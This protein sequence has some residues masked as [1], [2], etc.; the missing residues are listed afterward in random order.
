M[1]NG[2]EGVFTLELCPRCN[3]KY[4]KKNAAK[5]GSSEYFMCLRCGYHKQVADGEK[6]EYFCEGAYSIVANQGILAGAGF[7]HKDFIETQIP[8]VKQMVKGGKVFYTVKEES[9]YY[10][11]DSDN[12][13]K[14]EFGDS[15]EIYIGGIR[16]SN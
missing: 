12:G 10:L 2:I 16:K 1:N 11:V 7:E 8:K 6:K 13:K 9:K 5:D 14:Y 4:A 3:Y 15:D